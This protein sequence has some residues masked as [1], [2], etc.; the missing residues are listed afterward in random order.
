[1]DEQLVPNLS[2]D[3]FA[4][5]VGETY[6]LISLRLTRSLDVFSLK[7]QLGTMSSAIGDVI[8]LQS[9]QGRLKE[10]SSLAVQVL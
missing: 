9:L 1:M 6:G 2:V 10:M 3:E 8:E 4:S 7:L 5:F